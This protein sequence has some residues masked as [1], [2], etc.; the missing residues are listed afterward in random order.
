[1]LDKYGVREYINSKGLENILDKLYAVYDNANKIN[2]NSLPEKF[3][4]KT[5][6]GSGTN[7]FCREKSKFSFDEIK[8]LLNKW[9]SRDNF[10][11]GRE[12]AYKDITPKIIIEEYLEDNINP[13]DGINDYKFL[14]FNGKAKCII[15]HSD[16][17]G[18]HKRNYY[19]TEWNLIDVS[20]R[21]PNF[22]D[23]VPRPD[24]L[25]EMIHVAN[26]LAEDFPFVRVDLYWVNSKVYFGELTFYP[27]AG[28][29]IFIPDEFDFV[30]GKYFELPSTLGKRASL[31]INESTNII[32]ELFSATD[33]CECLY[34]AINQES[35]QYKG[36]NHGL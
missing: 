25:E 7:I 2:F 35:R 32:A 34:K 36:E 11:A 4:I 31:E 23:C 20:S 10:A 12:W 24:G 9:M 16:R 21:H 27:S 17:F 18:D 33:Y 28:Y 19:D 14:C 5:T 3:V 29:G 1:M 26:I 6:N 15:F 13:Y 30:L 8:P 22:G